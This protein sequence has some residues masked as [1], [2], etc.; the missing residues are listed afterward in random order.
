MIK[1]LRETKK[2]PK[3]ANMLPASVVE[4]LRTATLIETHKVKIQAIDD[5]TADARVRFPHLFR[6]HG[7]PLVNFSLV[8]G[9][10][11]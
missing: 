10:P 1:N 2:L 5:I 6:K 7:D 4:A 3:A 11:A 9:I 8:L